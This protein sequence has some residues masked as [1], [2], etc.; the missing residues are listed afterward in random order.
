MSAAESGQ[1][2][3][4]ESSLLSPTKKSNYKI[5]TQSSTAV[6]SGLAVECTGGRLLV[7]DWPTEH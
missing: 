4:K 2:S 6:Q 3:R 1:L 7:A 5:I